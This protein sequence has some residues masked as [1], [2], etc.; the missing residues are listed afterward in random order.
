[1][2]SS[3]YS[4]YC[5]AY[6]IARLY[7]VIFKKMEKISYFINGMINVGCLSVIL[8]LIYL[9]IEEYFNPLLYI[10]FLVLLTFCGI[11]FIGN[12][13]YIAIQYIKPHNQ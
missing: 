8:S 1:M 5:N 12:L 10:I 11:Y 3:L 13:I 7:E 6:Y 4:K 9:P 2:A